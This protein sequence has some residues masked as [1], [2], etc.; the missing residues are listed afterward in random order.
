MNLW[1]N[2]CPE[3]NPEIS[4]KMKVNGQFCCFFGKNRHFSPVFEVDKSKR[5]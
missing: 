5:T 2:D 3:F 1:T 4:L